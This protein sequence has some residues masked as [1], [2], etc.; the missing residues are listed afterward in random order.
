MR[1]QVTSDDKDIVT[2]LRLALQARVGAERYDLWFSRDTGLRYEAGTLVVSA[3]QEFTLERLRSLFRHDLQEVCRDL[4]GVPTS[5]QFLVSPVAA[6]A[7]E[8]P[9]GNATEGISRSAT[10]AGNSNPGSNSTSP[11]PTLVLDK[12]N[13]SATQRRRYESFESFVQGEGNRLG[14]TAAQTTASRLGTVSP[15]FLYGPTGSGK[16]HLLEAVLSSARRE[17]RVRRSV[18]LSSEQFTSQFL[19]ALQGSGLPSFRRKY[20]DVELLL[21]DD[22]QFFAGKRATL[23]EFLHTLD[24][25]HRDRRQIVLAADRP[26]AELAALGPEIVARLSGGLV[27]G[28]EPADAVTRLG[29]LKQLAA[30]VGLSVPRSVLESLAEQLSGDAR[31]LAG[32]IHR[33]EATSEALGKPINHELAQR[34]LADILRAS[35]R[36]VRLPDIERAVC[37]VFGLEPTSLQSGRKAKLVSQPRMLAMWLARKFTRS[38]L[39]EIGQHFGRRSHSTVI[40]AQKQ[41]NEWVTTGAAVHL[42]HGECSIDDAIR[43]VEAQLRTG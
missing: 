2:E 10:S 19:E 16:S 28:L 31:Q 8:T 40:S 5:V 26:P 1:L 18:L 12:P 39:S 7:S 24:T 23:V 41:V 32:A 42:A 4:L 25:L 9:G 17:G 3:P 30:K 35:R 29:I 34:A 38:A 11:V 15:L 37:E 36:I 21:I 22:V 20:R 43:R 13:G 6:A 14:L 33:L 27:C